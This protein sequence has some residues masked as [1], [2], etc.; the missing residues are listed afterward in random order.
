MRRFGAQALA[1]NLCGAKT[2][3]AICHL[4][5][6]FALGGHDAHRFQPSAAKYAIQHSMAKARLSD[7]GSC[8][9]LFWDVIL[10]SQT[11]LLSRIFDFD[12]MA[13]LPRQPQFCQLAMK[14]QQFLGCEGLSPRRV[15]AL[16]SNAILL[17]WELFHYCVLL[18]V[19][20]VLH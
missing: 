7:C 19:L 15:G 12:G 3:Q 11:L 6:I 9:F 1:G 5:G 14:L 20:P 4:E 18:A 13:L 10:N 17:S 16:G 8:G 2:T